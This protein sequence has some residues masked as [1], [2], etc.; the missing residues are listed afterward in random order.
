MADESTPGGCL[1]ALRA[2]LVQRRRQTAKTAWDARG[3]RAI[4]LA[5]DLG[6]KLQAIQD[7]I[8]AV[9]KAILD[10]QIMEGAA[11]TDAADPA[12]A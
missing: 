7:A 1:M 6:A 8:E 2:A 3:D 5:A 9:D 10:E 4:S 11:P 12:G